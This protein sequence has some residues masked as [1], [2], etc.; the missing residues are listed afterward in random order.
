MWASIDDEAGLVCQRFGLFNHHVLDTRAGRSLP[1]GP[2]EPFERIGVASGD[3]LDAAIREVAGRSDEP[4]TPGGIGREVAEA[5]T[6]HAPAHQVS[7]RSAHPVIV[8]QGLP[9]PDATSV[10]ALPRR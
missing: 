6:L 5:N 10:R 2:L 3:H 8:A 7:P 1:K 9:T 4:F